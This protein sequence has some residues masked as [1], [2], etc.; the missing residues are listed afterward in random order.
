[1]LFVSRCIRS[2]SKQCPI[3]VL[4]ILCL[5]YIIVPVT[6]RCYMHVHVTSRLADHKRSTWLD[7][8]PVWYSSSFPLKSHLMELTSPRD[9]NNWKQSRLRQ[10]SKVRRSYY[11]AHCAKNG[12]AG[13]LVQWPKNCENLRRVSIDDGFGMHVK[14][15]DLVRAARRAYPKPGVHPIQA[16]ASCI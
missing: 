7:T 5:C 9:C 6:L 16:P 13:A 15:V 8:L 12:A 3:M 1:M 2:Q 10:H 14:R 4:C 11:G